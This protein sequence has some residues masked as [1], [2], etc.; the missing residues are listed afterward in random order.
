[1]R[2]LVV[3]LH[4]FRED[5]LS[6]EDTPFLFSLKNGFGVGKVKPSF[7]FS[8]LVSLWTGVLPDKHN[9]FFKFVYDRRKKLRFRRFIPYRIYNYC[10]NIHRYL[11]GHD[12]YTKVAPKR[13]SEDFS[14]QKR[15][16]YFHPNAFGV[17]TLFDIFREK[18]KTFS[19]YEHPTW[20]TERGTRIVL[21]LGNDESRARR[22]IGRLKD[23]R[24]LYFL[25]LRDSDVIG[26]K[27]GPD[28]SEIRKVVRKQD[29]IVEEILRN[30]HI[31]ED[32]I[33]I[34]SCYGMIRVTKTIDLELLL[35]KYGEG[36]SYFLDSNFGRFWFLED[37]LRERIVSILNDIDCGHVLSNQERT[38]YGID[39]CSGDIHGHLIFCVDPSV[40]IVPNFFGSTSIKGMHSY[41]P[42]DQDEF[43]MI[44]CNRTMGSDAHIVDIAP[45]LLEMTGIKAQDYDFDGRSLLTSTGSGGT[46]LNSWGAV[47]QGA[48]EVRR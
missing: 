19:F 10:F 47:G 13:E 14:V 31:E 3:E 7:A 1:M 18:H 36:Y 37:D 33:V 43:G 32:N 24:D 16:H 35:P 15:F 42:C 40:A 8:S 25:L 20:G 2:T 41:H 34:L 44:M 38:Q 22:F 29:S 6:P 26:H 39:A 17:P 5:Y 23:R 27:Y 48:G 28:S 45:T 21:G 46:R 11:V 4:G 9:H 30:F 12:Y